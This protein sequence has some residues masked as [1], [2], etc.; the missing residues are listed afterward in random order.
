V[1]SLLLLYASVT[2]ESI[3]DIAGSNNL[4]W[5][6]TN[7]DI[8]GEAARK[9]FLFL[10]PQFVS[11]FERPVRYGALYGPLVTFLALLFVAVETRRRPNFGV[12]DIAL[13]FCSSI[14]WLWLC[15]GIAFDWS[16]TDNLNELIGRDGPWGWGGGG[17]LY[18]LLG[19]IC[20]NAV[21]LARTPLRWGWSIAGAGTT[22]A[23]VPLGWWLL[24]LGLE[25]EVEK[26]GQVFSGV[27][28]LLGPDRKHLMSADV[29][30]LRWSSVQVAVVTVI[31]MGARLAEA[32]LA[33]RT[34]RNACN[35]G[36][37]RFLSAQQ[38]EHL[39]QVQP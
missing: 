12:Q 16:S 29:L 25:Q 4:H 6:V 26:Y 30:F 37:P 9:L 13:L 34:K 23:M 32:P 17:Y 33:W 28:F 8:W 39:R 3:A 31:A 24:N 15:K 35:A 2:E 19:V 20:A 18:A 1:I 22:L 36:S 7:K 14:L 10:P 5:F 11:F 38:P 27:Q 21:L